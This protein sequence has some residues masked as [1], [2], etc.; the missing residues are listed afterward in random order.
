MRHSAAH[1]MAAAV[2]RIFP[3]VQ[4]DIGP[5]TDD[6]FY[7]DFDLPHRLSPEDFPRIEEEMA[8]L[9]Q[10]DHPFE[11]V[12]VSRPEAE[13]I[14]RDL[15]QT[16]K[17]ERLAD[18]PEG[19]TISFYRSG[20]FIYLCRGPHLA[21]T[22]G[23]KAFK[24]L[25][26][27]GSYYRGRETNPMLQRLYG[28]AF[29][30]ERELD[31][32]LKRLEQA[33]LRDHRRI[34]RD[35]DLFSTSEAVGP[36]LILWHQKGARVRLAIEDYW[37]R[38]HLSSGYEIIYTPHLGRGGLWETS[39]HLGFYRESMYAPMTIDDVEYFIKPMNCPFHIQI[40]R[41]RKWSYRDLPRRWAELGTVYRYE[42]AGVL[43]GLFRVRGFTQDD[44]HIYCTPEQVDAE[45][46]RVMRFAMEMWRAFGFREISAYLSTRPSKSVGDDG[47]W[48]QATQALESALR[49][50]GV[51]Y[52]VDPGGGAF[53]GPKID[54]RVKDAIGRE[55]QV[56]TFKFDFNLPERF[57]LTYV[58]A[59][60]REHRPY[61]VHRALLGSIERFFGILVE[62]YGGA[63]PLWLA[64]EQVRIL[65][66]T[67]K[68]LDYGRAVLD[69]LAAAGFRASVDERSEKVGAKIRDAQV[70]KVP[71]MLVVGPKEIEGGRVS[72]RSRSAG[73]QGAMG[74]DDFV[75][76]LRIEEAARAA[77]ETGAGPS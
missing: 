68:Q 48:T 43:N 27:A 38:A 19:E 67:E 35:L 65:P 70:E 17:V 6:G 69:R 61:M 14:L 60:G 5:S 10:A 64:P 22:G 13:K 30:T 2:W 20:D 32:Y 57:D 54:L 25:S 4:L 58:G 31:D 3:G 36:G 29:P 53:Y 33:K 41:A 21:G 52:E 72:V 73:D 37:R 75:E 8:R 34:G 47:R 42:K 71:Y 63:F 55:W 46:R 77:S 18:I 45:L 59:D 1:V 23:V 24:L 26:V 56:S 39:G 40:Y 12:E 44:A 76:K 15:G 7:Y 16:Y 28:A 51:A 62:H 74:L 50:E 66:L 49:E 9:I 11:R